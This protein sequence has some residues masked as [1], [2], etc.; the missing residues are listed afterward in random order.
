MLESPHRDLAHNSSRAAR[1]VVIAVGVACYAIVIVAGGNEPE[2]SLR[3]DPMLMDAIAI[4][5]AHRQA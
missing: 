4:M 5:P 3:L 1:S 2:V